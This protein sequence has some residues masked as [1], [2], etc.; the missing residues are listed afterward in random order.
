VSELTLI[1]VSMYLCIYLSMH[2]FIYVSMSICM[3]NV[4]EWEW[5]PNQ[6]TKSYAC[7]G[8]YRSAMYVLSEIGVCLS[9]LAEEG[10]Q[11]RVVGHSLGGAVAALVTYMLKSIDLDNIHCFAYG[12][13]SCLDEYTAEGMKSCVTSVV[14]HDDFIARVTPAS[15]R[16]VMLSS[17]RK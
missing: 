4:Q 6:S 9:M 7:G 16:Y 1:S 13:P 17:S 10:Y 2:L 12:I 14:L 5:L 15:I 8:I 3:Y 11:I